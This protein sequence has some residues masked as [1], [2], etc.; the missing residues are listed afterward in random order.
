METSSR[1]HK[2]S[3][4]WFHL[5]DVDPGLLVKVVGKRYILCLVEIERSDKKSVFDAPGKETRLSLN[6]MGKA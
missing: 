4:V 1:M 5:W 6:D 3:D 2:I